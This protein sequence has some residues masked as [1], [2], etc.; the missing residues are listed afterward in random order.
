MGLVFMVTG[1]AMVA[2]LGVN[3]ILGRRAPAWFARRRAR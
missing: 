3:A 1:A 2:L